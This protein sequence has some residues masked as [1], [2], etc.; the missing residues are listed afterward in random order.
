MVQRAKKP[1]VADA[2]LEPYQRR[3]EKP[4][5]WEMVWAETD[6]YTGKLIHVEAGK[7]LSLQYHDCKLETQC[8]L[9]G[10]ALLVLEDASGTLHEIDMRIGEGYTVR[11]FQ[12][13]RLIAL[14]DSEVAEVSTPERGTTVRVEDDFSRLNETESVRALP[15]RGWSS[16]Q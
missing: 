12:T 5:G 3:V 7:R 2:E 4:W 10:R 16:N 6:V 9:S 13:H 11:P 1:L 14:L 8:L 15:N